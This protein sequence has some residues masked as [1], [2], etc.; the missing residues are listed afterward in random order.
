MTGVLLSPPF[1]HL[2]VA[3]VSVLIGAALTST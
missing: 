1:V 3:L 2:A